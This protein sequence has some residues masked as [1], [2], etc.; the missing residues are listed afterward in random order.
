MRRTKRRAILWY[1][2][3]FFFFF[4]NFFASSSRC[5]RVFVNSFSICRVRCEGGPAPETTLGTGAAAP[6]SGVILF[7]GESAS[8]RGTPDRLY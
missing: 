7:P 8:I 1:L 5:N 3:Y 6:S 2:F 4:S